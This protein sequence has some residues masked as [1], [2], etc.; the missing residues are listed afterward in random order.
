[1]RAK[2]DGSRHQAGGSGKGCDARDSVMRAMFTVP[3]IRWTVQVRDVMQG[4]VS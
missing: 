4:T 3:G 1:M 2:F